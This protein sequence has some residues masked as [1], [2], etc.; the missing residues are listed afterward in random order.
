MAIKQPHTSHGAR[1]WFCDS[2]RSQSA[3]AD[4]S[5]S[6]GS[7]NENI[8]ADRYPRTFS[9]LIWAS[10]GDSSLPRKG[11]T[12]F[13]LC[14]YRRRKS[15][16]CGPGWGRQPPRSDCSCDWKAVLCMYLVFC[17]FRFYFVFVLLCIRGRQSSEDRAW[18][19]L[20][21]RL[22]V[23]GGQ[24]VYPNVYGVDGNLSVI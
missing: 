6:I 18:C 5:A 24:T 11:K 8:L 12:T 7:V 1:S 14:D 9:I 17:C 10:L 19:S 2:P 15:L 3:W 20:G 16:C 23:G 4:T 21:S 13:G 22:G